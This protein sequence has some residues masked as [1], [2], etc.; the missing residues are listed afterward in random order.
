MFIKLVIFSVLACVA[1]AGNKWAWKNVAEPQCNNCKCYRQASQM[2]LKPL[3]SVFA[4]KRY[5]LMASQLKLVQ[6]HIA[7]G[8]RGM[9]KT[10]QDLADIAPFSFKT[11]FSRGMKKAYANWTLAETVTGS[12]VSRIQGNVMSTQFETGIGTSQKIRNIEDSVMGDGLYSS[13][14]LWADEAN[15][16]FVNCFGSNGYSGWALYSTSSTLSRKAK[17]IVLQKISALGF[18]LK[19]AVVLPY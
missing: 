16:L 19:R 7:F 9:I 6:F 18:K 13:A 2:E 14:V 11:Y 15:I 3:R 17:Q 1:A 8:N 10:D 12:I 4:K 5:I